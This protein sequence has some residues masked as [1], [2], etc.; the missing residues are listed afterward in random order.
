[1]AIQTNKGSKL[2]A[3]LA[4]AKTNSKPPQYGRGYTGHHSMVENVNININTV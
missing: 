4:R 2:F 1:L 3:L